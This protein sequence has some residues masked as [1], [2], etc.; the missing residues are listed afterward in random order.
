[1]AARSIRIEIAGGIASGK[2]SL[3]RVLAHAGI[4]AIHEDFKRNPFYIAFYE[5]PAAYAFETEITFLLQHYH[6][7]KRYSKRWQS[8]CSDYS[9]ILDAAYAAVTLTKDDERIFE[10]VRERAERAL[11]RRSLL[12]HLQC[13]PAI[14]L[15]RIRR[16][17]RKAE[18]AIDIRY[19][20]R[21]NDALATKIARTKKSESVLTIDSGV[22][23]FVHTAVGKARVV[24]EVRSALAQKRER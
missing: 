7:Q 8:Y 15:A 10:A 23:D 21:I 13:D 5:D 18:A 24:H 2:T 22:I 3:A 4:R 17:N 16:R 6:A 14:E 20:T 12:I 11:P 1:M 9:L 19:L